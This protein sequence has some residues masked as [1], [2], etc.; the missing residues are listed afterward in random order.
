[1]LFCLTLR[2]N[3]D[4]LCFVD[5]IDVNA[6]NDGYTHAQKWAMATTSQQLNADYIQ[7]RTDAA[8]A[9]QQAAGSSSGA[10]KKK[11]KFFVEESDD[12]E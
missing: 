2:P 6:A 10:G 9:K 11:G 8:K 5:P 4:V 3:A 7:K 12:E 1:L